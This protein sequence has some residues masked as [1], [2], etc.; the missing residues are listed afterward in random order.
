[1]KNANILS[2]D[3]EAGIRELLS[4]ILQ[5]E[6]YRTTTAESVAEAMKIRQNMT[7]DLVLLD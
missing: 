6:G 1:M 7:P 3:D 2:V 4:E 5:E